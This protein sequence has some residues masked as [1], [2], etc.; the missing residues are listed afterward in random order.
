MRIIFF[1]CLILFTAQITM[2]AVVPSTSVVS[3]LMITQ[4]KPDNY[5]LASHMEMYVDRS[6]Q[7]TLQD[8]TTPSFSSQFVPYNFAEQRSPKNYDQSVWLRFRI[9]NHTPND[10][11]LFLTT[12]FPNPYTDWELYQETKQGLV[13][14]K[15]LPKALHVSLFPLTFYAHS[16]QTYYMHNYSEGW[17]QTSFQLIKPSF[18]LLNQID[19]FFL[20]GIQYGIALALVLH[21]FFIYLFLRDKSYLLYIAFVFSGLLA[22]IF[23]DGFFNRLPNIVLNNWF[24]LH[25]YRFVM[26]EVGFVYILFAQ[27]I[28]RTKY[29]VP[30]INFVLNA[31]LFLA[32]PC[33]IE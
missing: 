14:L 16:S 12:D 23:M 21:S 6:H 19:L 24:Y 20:I 30:K 3:P 26:V 10:V 31:Q 5:N 7:L 4:D 13:K 33:T 22:Y 32:I 1:L 18:H 15:L 28:L 25:F 8:V 11:H 17:L 2:A 27:N 9:D 29:F